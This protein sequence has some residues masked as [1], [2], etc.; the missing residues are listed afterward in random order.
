MICPLICATRTSTDSNNR[1]FIY[2]VWYSPSVNLLNT[3]CV[4]SKL[5][6][7][8]C[9]HIS[10]STICALVTSRAIIA[11]LVSHDTVVC[12]AIRS[13]AST[14]IANKVKRTLVN[15]KI[16]PVTSIS[17]SK[18]G[19]TSIVA[20]CVVS[21][22]VYWPKVSGTVWIAIRNIL[23]ES[24]FVSSVNSQ[25]YFYSEAVCSRSNFTSSR[26]IFNINTTSICTCFFY[27]RRDTCSKPTYIFYIIIYSLRSRNRIC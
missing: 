5:V 21:V 15:I 23:R 16:M 19:S 1:K 20:T 8:V 11:L 13:G 14:S 7:P 4:C 27:L 18:V 9:S 17:L 2:A 26:C 24:S 10:I 25:V 22:C 3:V 12:T 6:L